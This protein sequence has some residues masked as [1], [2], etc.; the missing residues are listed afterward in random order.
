MTTD[1]HQLVRECLSG[2]IEAFGRLVV[3]HQDRLYNTLVHVLGS[4]EEAQDAVQDAFVQAY[5]KLETFRG[6]A[7]FSSWL[8]RIALNA[9][10]SSRRK[11]RFSRTSLDTRRD[12][13]ES[14]PCDAR[15]DGQPSYAIELRERQ[16]LVRSALAEL[17]EEFRSP[18][19]LK[20]IEG[21]KYQEIAE[22]LGCP[23]GTVRSRIH[24]AR[25]EL[26]R[27][28]QGVLG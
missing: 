21:F 2:E 19:V 27:K 10:A 5:R 17:P 6:E 11:R 12:V 4:P 7:A 24:R 14:D 15:P 9:A 22:I 26:R 13:G 1:D 3:R 23:V 28:L 8:F 18:L 25:S 20:E 16:E